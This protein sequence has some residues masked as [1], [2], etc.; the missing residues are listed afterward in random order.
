M[1]ADKDGHLYA[2]ELIDSL[3]GDVI[4]SVGMVN[5]MAADKDGHLYA[6]EL[7]DSLTG[8]VIKSVGMKEL[9]KNDASLKETNVR[10]DIPFENNTAVH[11]AV[12]VW[13]QAGR[14]TVRSLAGLLRNAEYG[15]DTNVLISDNTPA[16]DRFSVEN[17][18]DVNKYVTETGNIYVSGESE[19]VI[20]SEDAGDV[21]SGIS[22]ITAGSPWKTDRMSINMSQKTETYMFR[23]NQE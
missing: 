9:A 7:V 10:F 18:P 13:D 23:G 3:T 19:I 8:D 5:V 6:V 22:M 1:A 21:Y 20:V 14:K 4:K 15:E 2:V 16:N 17:G 11:Y 12:V